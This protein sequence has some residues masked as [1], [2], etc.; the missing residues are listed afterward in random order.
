[1]KKYL[2]LMMVVM[3]AG[4]YAK[5]Y[6]EEIEKRQ[7]TFS[8]IEELSESLEDELDEDAPNWEMVE[9]QSLK[10]VEHTKSLDSLFS[11]ESAEDSRARTA[12]WDNPEKFDR[13]M[14]Q[15]NSGFQQLNHASRNRDI[16]AAQA[17]LEEAQD[18]CSSCH[19]SYRSLW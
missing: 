2:T 10:L 17:G 4:S 1:M 12:I 3:A 14:A 6:H 15:L 5:N 9:Q 7:D 18:T 13:L 8:A 19:R 11:P 16:E